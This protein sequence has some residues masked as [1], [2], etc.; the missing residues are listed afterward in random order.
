MHLS[1]PGGQNMRESW[2][3]G[4][5]LSSDRINVNILAVTLCYSFARWYY[6]GKLGKGYMRYVL[7]LHVSIQI[8]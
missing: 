8:N 2:G 7:Q 1:V 3:D 4:N 6:W 5:V